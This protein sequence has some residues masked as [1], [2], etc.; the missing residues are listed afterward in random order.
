MCATAGSGKRSGAF[1]PNVE[2]LKQAKETSRLRK[3]VMGDAAV[4]RLA[5][6]ECAQKC[7]QLASE[8]RSYRDSATWPFTR[9]FTGE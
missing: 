8:S 4:S 5:R 2:K 1:N 3:L 9:G 7:A 6:V